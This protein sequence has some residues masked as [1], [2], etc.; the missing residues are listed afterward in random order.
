MKCSRVD[1]PH[2]PVH[3]LLFL[4]HLIQCIVID[5]RGVL[6]L[7]LVPDLSMDYHLSPRCSWSPKCPWAIIC[8]R[9]VLGLSLVP[10]VTLGYHLSQRCPWCVICPRGVLGLSFV[11]EVTLVCYLSPRY[12]TCPGKIIYPQRVLGL[13]FVPPEAAADGRLRVQEMQEEHDV[14]AQAGISTS[15]QCWPSLFHSLF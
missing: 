14:P 12:P 9:G 15:A 7:S 2:N 1:H 10:K 4:H 5:P 8:P 13:S 6:G 11:P 3:C